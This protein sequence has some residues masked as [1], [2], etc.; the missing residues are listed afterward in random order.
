MLEASLIL[1]LVSFA[2][3]ALALATTL[4]LMRPPEQV[5]LDQLRWR[6]PA[7]PV[8]V[9]VTRDDEQPGNASESL[10]KMRT[11]ESDVAS[12]LEELRFH[13]V[14]EIDRAFDRAGLGDSAMTN[15]HAS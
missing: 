7:E 14:D 6:Q 1:S 13:N 5:T 9:T 8:R 3:S 2:L 4:A 12:R 10:R 11:P 15:N